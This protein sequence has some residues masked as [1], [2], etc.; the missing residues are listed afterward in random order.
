MV[1]PVLIAITGTQ[2]LAGEKPESIQLVTEGSYCCEPGFIR[3]S[4]V[5]SEMTGMEGVVTSFTVEDE[6]KLTLRRVGKVNSE[7]VFVQGQRH[8]SLYDAGMAALLV[9]V[10]LQELTVLLNEHAFSISATQSTWSAVPAARTAITS[11]SARREMCPLDRAKIAGIIKIQEALYQQS[12]LTIEQS[13]LLTAR[14]PSMR[15]MH[16]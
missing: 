4:Y 6:Q 16:L 7:M 10:E 9:G 3:F 11:R 12:V 13:V 8:E 1:K 15:S 14:V 5:E 2:Q